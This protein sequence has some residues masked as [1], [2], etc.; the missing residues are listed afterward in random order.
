MI[1]TCRFTGT[2]VQLYTPFWPLLICPPLCPAYWLFWSIGCEI[3]T[4]FAGGAMV[5]G[6]ELCEHPVSS[7]EAPA[8]KN[9]VEKIFTGFSSSLAVI[10][11]YDTRR[12]KKLHERP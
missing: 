4:G 9:K 5:T 12:Q 2:S 1:C 6:G 3:V 11:F 7:T 10:L 8:D